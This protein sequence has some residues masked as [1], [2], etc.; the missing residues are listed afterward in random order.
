MEHLLSM[1]KESNRKDCC[2]FIFKTYY[3]GFILVIDIF[4]FLY[5]FERNRILLKLFFEN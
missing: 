5:S 3:L 4:T 2:E 1:E